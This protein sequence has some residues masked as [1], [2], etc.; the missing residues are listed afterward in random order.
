MTS[1]DEAVRALAPE[2]WAGVGPR[3]DRFE[4]AWERGAAAH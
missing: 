3:L 4:A 2:A 1:L